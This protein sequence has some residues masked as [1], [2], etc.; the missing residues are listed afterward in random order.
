MSNGGYL[1]CYIF[2]ATAF[3]YDIIGKQP[4]NI[5]TTTR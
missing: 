3:V 5:I 2:A 1:F 4:N